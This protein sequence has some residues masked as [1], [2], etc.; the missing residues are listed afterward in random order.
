MENY[1]E[2]EALNNFAQSLG[3]DYY[4]RRIFQSDKRKTIDKFVLVH[5]TTSISPVFDY[6]TLNAFMIGFMEA[7]KIE[8]ERR[9]KRHNLPRPVNMHK[10]NQLTT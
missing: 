7:M 10:I 9:C 2:L 8:P 4:V 5:G 1:T 6:E 3:T